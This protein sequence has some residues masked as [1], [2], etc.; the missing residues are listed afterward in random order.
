MYKLCFENNS[1]QPL[2]HNYVIC[3]KYTFDIFILCMQLINLAKLLVVKLVVVLLASQWDI[4]DTCVIYIWPCLIPHFA[5]FN[6]VT[7]KAMCRT[8]HLWFFCNM[9]F[10]P[11][12]AGASQVRHKAMCNISIWW[13][14]AMWGIM[15]YALSLTGWVS[16]AWGTVPYPSY[17]QKTLKQTFARMVQA[18]NLNF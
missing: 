8:T 12:M 7:D 9:C 17:V 2:N 14:S 3:K 11:H 16:V 10:I 18:K 15:S 5:G 1:F 4:F 6:H 13:V